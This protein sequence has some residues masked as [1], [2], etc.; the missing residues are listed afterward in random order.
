MTGNNIAIYLSRRKNDVFALD[1]VFER[2]HKT[3]Q[4]V[5]QGALVH[6]SS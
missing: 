4:I 2:H 1:D 5:G 6:P 3:V